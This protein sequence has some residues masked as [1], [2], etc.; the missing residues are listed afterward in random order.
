MGTKETLK[1]NLASRSVQKK[2]VRALRRQGI[3]PGVIYGKGFE[4]KLVQVKEKDFETVY[5]KSHG[6]AIID[7]GLDG[8]TIHVL[9]QEL[10]REN[11]S[12]KILH[13]DFHKVDLSRDVSV[14]IP[15]VFAGEA[16]VE[17]E[18]TGKVGHEATSIHIKC[19]PKDIPT[20]IEVD[21][22]TLRDKHDVI[23]ASDLKLPEGSSLAH[24]VSEDK[25]IATVSPAKFAELEAEELPEEGEEA[26]AAAEEGEST[27]E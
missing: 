9:I 18:G 27:E 5:K 12:Q 19:S 15:L 22:S 24:G 8:K 11:V 14:E 10:Q 13:I 16:P 20:E 7:A 2:K 21:I 23:H 4:P 25:V 1:L 26:A 17:K 6:N 3:I